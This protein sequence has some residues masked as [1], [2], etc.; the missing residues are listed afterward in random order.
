MRSNSSTNS[1]VVAVGSAV[2]TGT[3]LRTLLARLFVTA[4]FV[5][6]AWLLG[7]LMAGSASAST[8]S[9]H[10]ETTAAPESATS[11]PGLLGGLLG[12]VGSVVD[13]LTQT[14]G[15]AVGGPDNTHQS[16]PDSATDPAADH[17]SAEATLPG[18]LPSV[19]SGSGTVATTPAELIEQAAGTQASTPGPQAPRAVAPAKTVQPKHVDRV[20]RSSPK[21]AT[22]RPAD[23][24][25]AKTVPASSDTRRQVKEP[26]SPTPPAPQAPPA[27]STAIGAG[28]DTTTHGKNG[29]AVAAR[30]ATLAP[31]TATGTAI[32]HRETAVDRHRDRPATAPD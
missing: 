26:W 13:G 14:V 10:A 12:G 22:S 25:V 11:N 19:S 3:R 15:D 8:S 1:G 5:V 4:G 9:G 32:D 27:P 6:A 30:D 17:S 18:L 31:P 29:F 23:Q 20:H 24:Q 28:H 2:R 7:S 16:H 21:H